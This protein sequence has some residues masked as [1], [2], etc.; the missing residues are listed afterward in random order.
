MAAAA[1]VRR[2]AQEKK[3][4]AFSSKP[5]RFSVRLRDNL[6]FSFGFS[7]QTFSHF[8]PFVVLRSSCHRI[9]IE[10]DW[11]NWSARQASNL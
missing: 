11:R 3:K 9:L 10:I 2:L 5:L 7:A 6:D 4:I 8:F 1:A